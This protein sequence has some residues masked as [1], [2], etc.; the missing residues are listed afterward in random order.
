MIQR[1]RGLDHMIELDPRLW[2]APFT[3]FTHLLYEE[4][5]R[6]SERGIG[7]KN[8]LLLFDRRRSEGEESQR[9]GEA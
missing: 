2:Y 4:G 7:E 6:L 5:E 1:R 9:L 3:E 8:E